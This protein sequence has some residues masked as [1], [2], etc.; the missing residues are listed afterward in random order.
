MTHFTD[1]GDQKRGKTRKPNVK[2]PEPA[3][4]F[5]L[6]NEPP[7][8]PM[9]VKSGTSIDAAKDVDEKTLSERRQAVLRAVRGA[10]HGLA[11]FQI[12]EILKIPDHWVT[13]SVEALIKMRK[14]E[15]HPFLTVENPKSGKACAVIIAIESAEDA[16]A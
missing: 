6:G 13:S 4:L 14:L 11:R 15:Q 16:A 5:D 3:S 9:R 7:P 8:T 2:A 12:A 1:P 10:T